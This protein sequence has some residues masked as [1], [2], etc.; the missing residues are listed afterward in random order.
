MAYWLARASDAMRHDWIK[1]FDARFWTVNFPRPMMAAVTT[2]APDALRV[3]LAFLKANDLAG[4]IWA[5][6]DQ[7]DHPLL[8]YETSHDYRG[9]TLRFRWQASGVMAL[10][11]VNGPVLTIE[12]RDAAGNPRA[13]YVRLWN[14]AAGSGTDAE[15]ALDFDMLAG[16]F[17]HPSEADPVWAGDIDRLFVSLVPAAYTGVDAPLA[18]SVEGHV[19]VSDM[20]CDGARSVLAIGDTFVPPHGT[21][22]ASGYDDSYNLTPARLL[23]GMVQTGF[24][25]V[26]NHYVG[27]SH[28][29]A[30]AWDAG[31]G[32]FVDDPARPVNAPAQAWHADFAARA[33]DAGFDLILSL[34]FELL[35]MHAPE[36]WKQRAANGSPALTGWSPP[37]TLLSPANDTAMAYLADVACAFVGIAT[38]AG[39]AP[40]L[41]IGEPWWWVGSDNRPY[42]YDAATI[43]A[44]AA[45]FSAY[46]PPAISD[47]RAT[48]TVAQTG[49]LGWLGGKLGAATL[50][51]RDSARAAFPAAKT[52]LLV[53]APQILRPDAP[54]LARANLP[55]AWA[56]PAWDVLQLEDYDYV[57]GGDFAGQARARAMVSET[58]GYPLE[59]QHYFAGF[60]R[61]AAD[62]G[63]WAAIDAAVTAA[64]ARG[65]GETFVWAWPQVARDGFVTFDIKGDEAVPAFHDVRFPLELGY[66]ATGGPQFSTQI[67]VTASGYEQ[68]NSSWADARLHYDAGVGVRSE[69]DLAALVGFFRA[70]RGP[71]HGFRF[72]D[73]LDHSSRDD[74]A[75]PTP[76][77]QPLGLGDGV[78]TRFA[79]RKTYG[80]DDPQARR[81]SRPDA[82]TMRVGVGGVEWLTGWTVADTGAIDF[83]QA[84][85]AGAVVTAGF[86][87]DV[88]VRFADDQINVS[89]AG[90]RT[91][92]VPSVPLVEIRED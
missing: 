62:V 23:R 6:V 38:D 85:A 76:F 32:A 92:D 42:I 4:L 1:R 48:M 64:R 74:G 71:A 35:D 87:F 39:Q 88:P 46:A 16:G 40:E 29:P 58:L 12:G 79:L 33:K 54:E 27:M 80:D 15:I 8:G 31:A 70:R 72:R 57:T 7:F 66:G 20:R 77:D 56:C 86:L 41:Q 52:H 36:A 14:Y 24:G 68:R 49:Y 61:D 10:D 51:L 63:Q 81:I 84:P 89:L 21:R 59:R 44:F 60:V 19:I 17:M 83:A 65:V 9:V 26:I 67:A 30:L 45:D 2:V 13:W 34:S 25:G 3:D 47:V 11:A 5:S 69:A 82:A 73:P 28:Y 75:V 43:T 37:S 22:I 50:R 91:G 18:G 90:W 78:Q 53:Y 55:A